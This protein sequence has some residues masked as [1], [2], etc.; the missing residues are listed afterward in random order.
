MNAKEFA[1]LYAQK[2]DIPKGKA[3]QYCEAFTELLDECF[4]GMNVGDRLTFYGFGTFT[5]KSTPAH[6][7]GDVKNGGRMMIPEKE[8]IAFTRSKVE[9]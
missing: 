5:K 1:A 9:K 3:L 6:E 7:I 4:D 8:R 2:C